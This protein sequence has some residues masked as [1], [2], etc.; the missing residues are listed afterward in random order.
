MAESDGLEKLS[1][2]GVSCN[3]GAL[4]R[5]ANRIG[6][7]ER[8]LE[9]MAT[10][11][12]T[13]EQDGALDGL[14]PEQY[15]RFR[16]LR[17]NLTL[18][19][20]LFDGPLLTFPESARI[21]EIA[22]RTIPEVLHAQLAA[23]FPGLAACLSACRPGGA[24]V[25]TPGPGIDKIWF[26]DVKT[27]LLGATTGVYH[28][29][30][31]DA[32][33]SFRL[34]LKRT[35]A[36]MERVVAGL[37]EDV[38]G[39]TCVRVLWAGPI[40]SVLELVAGASLREISGNPL[41]EP[42]RRKWSGGELATVAR[43]LGREAALCWKCRLWSRHSGNIV[44]TR[45]ERLPEADFV[46]ID[47][48]QSL[49]PVRNPYTEAVMPLWH[50]RRFFPGE[51]NG[52]Y[53]DEEVYRAI[54]AG[55]A[56][57]CRTAA[58]QAPRIARHLAE[59]VGLP[60]PEMTGELAPAE[61]SPGHVAELVR[62]LRRPPPAEEEFDLLYNRFYL[63]F[64]QVYGWREYRPPSDSGREWAAGDLDGLL[65]PRPWILPQTKD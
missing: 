6:Q 54:W 32:R 28:L 58:R 36:S 38:F 20:G 49:L 7:P 8:I 35:D 26:E 31:R 16:L 19:T 62:K 50:L 56:E 48:G 27:G 4:R 61:V 14:N 15:A 59:A 41:S 53:E 12:E 65:Q 13:V 17:G 10:F 43:E 34:V 2:L 55:W 24:A 3:A 52:P 9:G 21:Y 40:F 1:R 5:F 25:D 47:F 60:V 57:V 64:W 63:G 33:G 30:G 22:A 46:R 44:A 45:P 42:R 37:L 18:L 39:I 51:G 23:F 29:L 11:L